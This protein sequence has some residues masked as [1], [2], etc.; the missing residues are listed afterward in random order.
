M[1][2]K[3]NI[4]N[5]DSEDL[6]TGEIILAII[7]DKCRIDDDFLSAMRADCKKALAGISEKD[8]PSD[9]KINTVQNT[10]ET[11]HIVLPV[12]E[13]LDALD[14]RD[15]QLTEEEMA[16]ISGGEILVSVI[17]FAGAVAVLTTAITAGVALAA[18]TVAGIAAVA[19]VAARRDSRE[20]AAAGGIEAGTI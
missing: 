17:G 14:M 19:I 4:K 13:T 18:V 9:I 10:S 15:Y 12:Y 20:A 1:N 3:D 8:I 7:A 16:S 2:S 5:D 11:V 6:V